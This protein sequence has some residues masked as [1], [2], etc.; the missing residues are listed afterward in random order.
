MYPALAVIQVLKENNKNISLLW[1]GSND[2][3][4]SGLVKRA[5]I[6]FM[7]IPSAGLHGVG[8]K[9][10]PG[11]LHKLNKGFFASK[12]ILKDYKPDVLF[13][14]G[15]YV[16]VPM[17]LA[18]KKTPSVLYVPDIEPG[19]ALKVLSRSASAI[20]VTSDETR[21]FL[22]EKKRICLT[23]YP[24]RPELSKW[25]REDARKVFSLNDQKPVLFIFGGSRG[26]RSINKAIA[27]HLPELLKTAQIIHVTGELDWGDIQSSYTK[28]DP[29]MAKDYHITPYLHEEMGAAFAAADLVISR[30]GA[31][32]LGEF[33]LFGLPAVLVPYP[34]AWRYQ[35]V[36][37][38]YLVSKG[39][40]I[41]IQDENLPDQIVPTVSELFSNSRK[42]SMMKENMKV[43]AEPGA[44][45]KIAALIEE[46]GSSEKAHD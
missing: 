22:P 23:G 46:L 2:G 14:T 31:S 33:P 39:A 18:G 26:A 5:G 32:T 20:A 34:Y 25:K 9:A 24:T 29:E 4:E 35:I 37:A 6:E 11:N 16:A 40:A 27:S 36:N 44:A 38:D 21:S 3:L 19:Q 17:A 8:M 10:L 41:L 1:V 43:L 7:G 15:G 45:A 42:L 30:A 13:F 12:K 28:L